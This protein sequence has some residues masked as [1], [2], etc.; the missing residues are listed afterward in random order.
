MTLPAGTATVPR[1]ATLSTSCTGCCIEGRPPLKGSR[2]SDVGTR[3]GPSVRA[4]GVGDAVGV[5]AGAALVVAGVARRPAASRQTTNR[6][7]ASNAF[8]IAPSHY[9]C[10]AGG[11]QRTVASAQ[12]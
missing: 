12:P 6:V 2:S 9:G 3:L 7:P 11:D 1:L 4:V 10:A 5:S 8:M